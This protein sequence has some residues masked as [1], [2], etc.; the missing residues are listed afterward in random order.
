MVNIDFYGGVNEIGGNKILINHNTTSLFLDFGMSFSQSNKYFSEFLQPRKANGIQ[1][2]LELGL[3]PQ[4]KGIYR[5]DYLRHCGLNS[6]EKPAVEGLLLSHAH[7]DH[8]AYIHHLREDIPLYMTEESYFIL[9]VLEDTSA[10]SFI[11]MLKLKKNFHFTPKKNGEGYKRLGGKD[12]MVERD[13]HVV[14]PYENFQIGDFTIKS[15]PVDHSLP[16]ASAYI[17]ETADDTIAYTG[18]LRF[19][20]R[21][22]EITRKFVREAKKSNPN[23]MISEGTRID[24]QSN[25]TEEDIENKAKTLISDFKGLVIVNYPIRDFDRLVTFYKV[26]KDTGR[27]LVLNLKQA[28]M[29]NLFENKD[30]PDK[31][32]P[33]IDDIAVYKP[34]KGWGLVG[35]D[36]Y[37][38]FDGEW[39]CSSEIDHSYLKSDY[40]TWERDFLN[41]DNTINYR[42]LQEEPEKYIFR[43]DFFELKEL[44]D[45]KPENGIYIRSVTEPFDDEMEIDYKRVKNWLDHF[46]LPM[47]QMHASGHASGPEILDM[48]REVSP[49]VL[50]PI[51]TEHKEMFKELEEDG[52]NVVYPKLKC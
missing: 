11:D 35:N 52:I 5:E 49:D 51:H 28:Y 3:L 21:R 17:L 32:Y 27:T 13:V 50:Y 18:D 1:D 39:I 44:I 24:S 9:K 45:I 16:G 46:N 37:A 48:I 38:C 36:S 25:T 6:Q 14:K 20:G 42:D 43:C 34:R 22:P 15:A 26:A 47:H 10:V 4:I 12:A 8:S 7:M 2:F 29:L 41:L 31:D 40:K 30:Y 23:I 19:H 33:K